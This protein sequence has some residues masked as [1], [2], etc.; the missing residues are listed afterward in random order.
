MEKRPATVD[1]RLQKCLETVAMKLQLQK[2]TATAVAHTNSRNE[3]V[4]ASAT[5]ALQL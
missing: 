1:L 4:V 3:A 2:R 5:I